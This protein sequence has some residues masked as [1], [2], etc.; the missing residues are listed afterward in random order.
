MGTAWRFSPWHSELPVSSCQAS[1][2]QPASR[3]RNRQNVL[4]EALIKCKLGFSWHRDTSRLL[5]RS[6][7]RSAWTRFV[8]R[9][10]FYARNAQ[11]C[12]TYSH[13][14]TSLPSGLS[15]AQYRRYR[16]HSP[17]RHRLTIAHGAHGLH[18]GK[19]AGDVHLVG[20]G[21]RPKSRGHEDAYGNVLRLARHVRRELSQ[22]QVD[23]VRAESRRNRGSV[24]NGSVWNDLRGDWKDVR[25]SSA[26]AE[27]PGDGAGQPAGDRDQYWTDLWGFSCSHWGLNL[28]SEVFWS[29]TWRELHALRY[30]WARRQATEHNAW[31]STDG[32]PFLPEDFIGGNGRE[33]RILEEQRSKV[34]A[35]RANTALSSITSRT[36]PEDI[37]EL[38]LWAYGKA[39]KP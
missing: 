24:H 15:N 35:E 29:L 13:V 28:D 17:A 12:D 14:R 27:Q 16:L 20:G 5:Y 3:L 32:V 22:G 1:G 9:F 31:F 19:D 4:H 10:P 2:P 26:G 7:L 18:P 33:K 11:S 37:P 6:G 30:Q 8:G 38:P 21:R 39:G 23:P 36:K 34:N 25:K